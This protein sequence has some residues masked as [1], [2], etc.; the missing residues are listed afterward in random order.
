[1]PGGSPALSL[2]SIF[3][4]DVASPAGSALRHGVA[5]RREEGRPAAGHRIGLLSADCWR[6]AAVC[7]SDVLPTPRSP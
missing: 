7:A 2:C 4:C 5:H 3:F 6:N 1:M